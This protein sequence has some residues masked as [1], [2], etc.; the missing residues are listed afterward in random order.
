MARFFIDHPIFAWVIAILI[1]LAGLLSIFQ[2]P[3]AQYPGIAPTAIE[4]R[5]A[6]PGASAKVVEDS[7]IQVIE[8]NLTG[9]DDLQYISSTSDSSGVG[10]ITVTFQA[11][12]DPD[13]AQVQVQNKLQAAM[14]LLPQDVQQQGIRITKSST[15]FLMVLGF[16]SIME[17]WIAM[18][19]PTMW[20]LIFRTLSAG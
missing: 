7:V 13:I 8:Q 20:R 4:I 12:T 1:M 3:I 6:Y 9:L 16:V 5:T 14:P 17:K 2:L 10:Q 11:D 18:I 15:G 19:L